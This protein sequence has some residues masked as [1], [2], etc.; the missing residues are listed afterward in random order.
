MEAAVAAMEHLGRRGFLAGGLAASGLSL[1]PR[2]ALARPAERFAFDVSRNGSPLGRHVV[3][4][5]QRGAETVVEV[6]IDLAVTLAFVTVFR[7][8]HRAEEVWQDGRLVSLSSTTY[9]DGK[10]LFVEARAV[11]GGLEVTGSSGRYEAPADTLPTSYWNPAMVERDVLLNTQDGAMMPVT[12][13]PVGIEDVETAEGRLRARRYR[14]VG[15]IPLD[16]WYTEADRRWCALAFSMRGSDIGYRAVEVP[17]TVALDAPTTDA[18][19]I[20]R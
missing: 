2:S 9:D 4:M 16:L 18:P 13:S 5:R 10:D 15:E 6:A 11:Q 7:Y 20:A 19:T 3:K 17:R 8:R 12:T 1:L 14:L